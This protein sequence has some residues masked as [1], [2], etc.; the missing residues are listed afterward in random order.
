M[1]V[2]TMDQRN[3]LLKEIQAEDFAVYEAILYL[4]GHPDCQNALCYYRQHRERLFQ[5]KEEYEAL[6]GPLSIYGNKDGACWRW[7]DAPWPWEKEAN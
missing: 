7:I 4:N 5:L 6:Y 2:L 3:K 1:R